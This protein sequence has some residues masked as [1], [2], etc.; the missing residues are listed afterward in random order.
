MATQDTTEHTSGSDAGQGSGAPQAS[1][2]PPRAGSDGTAGAQ[3]SNGAQPSKKTK[4]PE[5]WMGI[6][7]SDVWREIADKSGGR[8]RSLADLEA[9]T[10]EQD[11]PSDEDEPAAAPE[12]NKPE[13]PAQR[14]ARDRKR[15]RDLETELSTGKR[16]LTRASNDLA[17]TKAENAALR[18]LIATKALEAAASQAGAL[19]PEDVAEKLKGRVRIDLADGTAEIVVLD[20]KGQATDDTPA[21]LVGGFMRMRPNWFGAQKPKPNAAPPKAP[22]TG[23]VAPAPPNGQPREWNAEIAAQ[24]MTQRLA[25]IAGGGREQG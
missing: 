18:S 20:E 21:S 16:D 12:P 2:E 22:P 11:K 1:P 17:S 14:D 15:I 8:I 24:R 19:N 23:P 7:K 6:G 5:Q 9:L 13:P 4:T 25:E 3:A 10:A